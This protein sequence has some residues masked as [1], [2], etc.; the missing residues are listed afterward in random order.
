LLTISFSPTIS[1]DVLD[2]LT[3]GASIDVLYT[4]SRL[5]SNGG[6]LGDIELD[7][8]DWGVGF[9]VGMLFEPVKGTRIGAAYHHGY[10]LETPTDTFLGQRGVAEASLPN[11]VHIGVT[12][13]VT[14]DIRI[15]AE[16]RWINWSRFDSIDISTPSLEGG[17]FDSLS[18]VSDVQGYNDSLF[19][20]IGTEYDV[21][22]QFTLRGGVAWDE[23]PTSDKFRTARIPDEDRLWFSVGASYNLT[24]SMSAD[25]GYSYLHALRDADVTLRFSSPGG[26]DAGD[27]VEYDG[28]AHIFSLG[29]HL[30]F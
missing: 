27:K 19:F 1:Y 4:E 17:P 21:T 23:T 13:S 10:D 18:S 5:T 30:K 28:G 8:H 29:W 15:M 2:N 11:W 26:A 16:G 9:S 24:D 14:D 25:I 3:F 12:Q 20:S 22:D 7:G 6:A